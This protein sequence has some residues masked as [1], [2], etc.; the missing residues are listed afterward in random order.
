MNG[1]VQCK[2][3]KDNAEYTAYIPIEGAVVGLTFE[4]DDKEGRWEVI[5]VYDI[6]KT[7][8]EMS[9]NFYSYIRYGKDRDKFDGCLCEWV[10]R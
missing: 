4:L 10:L 3:K 5:E 6:S 1:F 7:S 2:L 8:E 9:Y